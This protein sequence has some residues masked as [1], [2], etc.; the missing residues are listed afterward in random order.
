MKRER[1]PLN[2][3]EQRIAAKYS[4]AN[5][6]PATAAKRLARDLGSGHVGQFSDKGRAFLAYCVNRYR[7]QYELTIE[8]TAWVKQWLGWKEP[9]PPLPSSL[10]RLVEK[11]GHDDESED[12][13]ERGRETCSREAS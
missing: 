2:E 12:E 5:F 13:R 11:E 8:E 6:P 7:R 4:R 3:L 9:P 10:M 1:T